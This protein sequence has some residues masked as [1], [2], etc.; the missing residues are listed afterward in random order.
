MSPAGLGFIGFGAYVSG[1]FGVEDA[2]EGRRWVKYQG[3]AP[4]VY[5]FADESRMAGQSRVYFRVLRFR[6]LGFTLPMNPLHSRLW[7]ELRTGL[8]RFGVSDFT[9][10]LWDSP[11]KDVIPNSYISLSLSLSLCRFI[12]RV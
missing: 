10:D 12:Q 1:F 6:C 7:F 11:V 9:W 2:L 3:R 4:A 8:R 5:F